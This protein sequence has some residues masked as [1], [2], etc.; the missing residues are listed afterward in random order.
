MPLKH[1][2]IKKKN[3]TSLDN[4]QGIKIARQ[5]FENDEN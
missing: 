2:N 5:L 1:W 4:L 3:L